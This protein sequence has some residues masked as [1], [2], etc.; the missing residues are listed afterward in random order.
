MYPVIKKKKKKKKTPQNYYKT[1]L[2][3]SLISDT[4]QVSVSLG[5]GGVGGCIGCFTK[6]SKS[7]L[8]LNFQ[9]T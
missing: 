4:K 7:K 1:T 9:T 8:N 3:A 5:V 6:K 2:Y